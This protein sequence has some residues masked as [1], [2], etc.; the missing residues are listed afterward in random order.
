MN[1]K[2]KQRKQKQATWI[3]EPQFKRWDGNRSPT[4]H[5]ANPITNSSH[6]TRP[7]PIL[8]HISK[9]KDLSSKRTTN[10]SLTKNF[11]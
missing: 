4:K 11:R 9:D 2:R 6:G 1:S 10:Q 8:K 3:Q 7:L 5:I